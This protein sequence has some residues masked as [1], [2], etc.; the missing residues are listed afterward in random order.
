MSDISRGESSPENSRDD[1]GDLN[2]TN[3]TSGDRLPMWA[4]MLF[5]HPGAIAL[6]VLLLA[7]VISVVV[8]FEL[9]SEFWL[10]LTGLLTGLGQ[11]L[12]NRGKEKR[13]ESDG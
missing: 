8:R 12:A 5:E 10:A 13:D 4:R 2:E 9:P 1:G 11:Q 7:L 6:Y 3:E